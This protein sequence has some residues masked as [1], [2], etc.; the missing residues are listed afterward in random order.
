MIWDSSIANLL[1]DTWYAACRASPEGSVLQT[2]QTI[3]HVWISALHIQ[4]RSRDADIHAHR[5]DHGNHYPWGVDI[6]T[7]SLGLVTG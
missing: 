3:S 2:W 6:S 1:P 7:R 5:L 4:I